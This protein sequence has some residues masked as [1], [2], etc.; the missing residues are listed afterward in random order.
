MGA[1]VDDRRLSAADLIGMGILNVPAPTTDV[2]EDRESFDPSGESWSYVGDEAV[3]AALEAG[4]LAQALNYHG[5][6]SAWKA[7]D[8]SYR[9]ILLQYRAVTEDA[10]FATASE[11]AERFGELYHQTDG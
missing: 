9:L 10:T 4:K 8:G 7:D 11:A 6:P 3:A 5:I 2:P 1:T